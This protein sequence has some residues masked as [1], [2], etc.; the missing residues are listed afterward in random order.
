MIRKINIG[1]RL[2]LVL[3]LAVVALLAIGINGIYRLSQMN[4]V[5]ET[6]VTH[7]LQALE[8][9]HEANASFLLMRVN[10]AN[11]MAAANTNDLER[12]NAAYFEAL[13]N[14]NSALE[15]YDALIEAPRAR[16]LFNQTS[17]AI[18]R[19]ESLAAEMRD[20]MSRDQRDQAIEKLDREVAPAA[21]A[22][23]QSI[24]ELVA[25]Q[26]QRI[27]A[28]A[29]TAAQTYRSSALVSEIAMGLITLLV[30]LAAWLLTRSI[31]IPLRQAVSVAAL[32]SENDLTGKIPVEGNDEATALMRALQTMQEQ[33]RSTIERI[34]GSSDQLASS[35]E[36]LNAI[37][38]ETNDSMSQQNAELE[39]AASAVTELTTAIEEV[40]ANATETARVSSEADEQT[41]LGLSVVRE[42]VQSIE[43]LVSDIKDNAANTEELSKRVSDVGSVL[44]V[45]RTIAEQTNLLALNAAIEA[46]R[47]GEAGRGFAVVA[48]EVRGL[49]SRT[50]DSTR[51]IEEIISSVEAGTNKAVAS[52]NDSRESAHHTLQLGLSAGE[53]LEK[54]AQ[55]I[56]AIS[57][58]NTSSASACEEQAVV[59]KEV[60][61]NLTVIRDLG[62]QTGSGAEQTQESSRELARLA[63]G[64]RELVT[65]F[66]F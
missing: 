8:S 58:R 20:M 28:S 24:E 45:I 30:I 54:I 3:G 59:A 39:Q 62:V 29:D 5:T 11:L 52:M 64:L 21:R 42:T 7:R 38:S 26:R 18:K 12:Y 17:D 15:T 14:K 40:A 53:A 55:S 35:S 25:F 1:I 10:T 27:N 43:Q 4:A 65:A 41:Q 46:A 47:A 6:I 60:D 56:T 23:T 61:K 37:T 66:K 31:V 57:E 19:Y 51:E 9:V 2:G 63:E 13:A 36:E 32:V 50:A 22:V 48:D 34:S 16:T 49:A 44:D 33:L